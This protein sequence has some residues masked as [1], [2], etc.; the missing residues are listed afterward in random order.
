MKKFLIAALILFTAMTAKSQTPDSLLN[1]AGDSV[2][3]HAMVQ[4]QIDEARQKQVLDKN[5]QSRHIEQQASIAVESPAAKLTLAGN[6]IAVFKQIPINYKV[7]AGLSFLILFIIVIRRFITNMDRKSMKVL[8][9]KIG[10]MREEKV[11][12]AKTNS[13]Q[14]KSRKELRSTSEVYSVSEEQLSRAARK[15]NLSKGEL[16]LA[17]RLR[18]F[19]VKKMQEV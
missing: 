1:A 17:A 15:M 14:L 13:K 10:M 9:E 2:D 7:Y 16:I 5:N 12:G 6:L 3:I 8:K 18:F 4:K 19:E 11:G